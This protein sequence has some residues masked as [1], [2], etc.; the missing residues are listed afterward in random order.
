MMYRL[1]SG[2]RWCMSATRPPREFSM[3]IMASAAEPSETAAK[4]SSKL[5]QAMG[6]RSG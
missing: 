1:D 4:A 5:S 6:S 2:S 3:G